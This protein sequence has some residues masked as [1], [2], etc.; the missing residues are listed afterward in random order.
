[1]AE[2][3]SQS[4]QKS[5]AIKLSVSQELLPTSEKMKLKKK[6]EELFPIIFYLY[7]VLNLRIRLDDRTL[8]F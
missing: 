7:F 5:R 2:Q 4:H 8:R 3:D 6:E 1:M